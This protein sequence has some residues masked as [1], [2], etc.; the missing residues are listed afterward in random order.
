MEVADMPKK[1]ILESASINESIDFN[2]KT[3]EELRQEDPKVIRFIVTL[4]TTNIKNRNGRYYPKAVIEEGMNDP[5]I[6][7]IMK[8]NNFFLEI[9][10][11]S[12]TDISRQQR[13]EETNACGILKKF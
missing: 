12:S 8:R 1:L 4:Q 7:D 11:P 13:V 3:I 10:H 5:R 2:G 9:G 6:Q